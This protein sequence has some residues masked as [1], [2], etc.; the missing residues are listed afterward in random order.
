[1]YFQAQCRQHNISKA[2]PKKSQASSGF[3]V[4]AGPKVSGT[5]VGGCN[6]G[7]SFGRC[8]GIGGS[9]GD[10]VGRQE[11]EGDIG[12]VFTEG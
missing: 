10:L 7:F 8:R 2:L 4:L 6:V 3:P 11:E 5:I 1:M 12:F 9:G